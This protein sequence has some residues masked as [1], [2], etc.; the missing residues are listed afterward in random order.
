MKKNIDEKEIFVYIVYR[1]R[2]MRKHRFLSFF[3]LLIFVCIFTGT[4]PYVPSYGGKI[5][6]KNSSSYNLYIIFQTASDTERM[7]CIE[8]NE[9]IQITHTDHYKNIANP[10]NYYTGISFYDFDSGIM[11][12]KMNVNAGLFAL[13]SGSIDSNNALFEFTINDDLLGDGL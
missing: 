5:R 2:M 7:L 6:V 9:Q 3:F 12:K 10:A 8:K 1:E 11:L 13:S 4:S